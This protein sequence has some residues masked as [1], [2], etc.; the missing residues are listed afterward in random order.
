MTDNKGK[1]SNGFVLILPPIC[2]KIWDVNIYKDN[3]NKIITSLMNY[4]V[5]SYVIFAKYTQPN[6]TIT[7]ENTMCIIIY[8]SNISEHFSNILT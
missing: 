1:V 2:L 7:L 8:L 3:K 6:E 5:I 4:K